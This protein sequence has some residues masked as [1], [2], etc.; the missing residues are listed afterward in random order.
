[1]RDLVEDWDTHLKEV[2]DRTE[3]KTIFDEDYAN[4]LLVDSYMPFLNQSWLDRKK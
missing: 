2:Y 3:I 4:N 1:M